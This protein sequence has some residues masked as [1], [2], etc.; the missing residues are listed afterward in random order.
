MLVIHIPHSST[1][2]PAEALEDYVIDPLIYQ[3]LVVDHRTDELFNG[4]EDPKVI[5]PYSRVFCDVERLTDDPLADKGQGIYYYKTLD[6]REL[7]KHNPVTHAHVMKL[8][9]EHHMRVVNEI[10]QGLSYFPKVCLVDAHSYSG[11]QANHALGVDTSH[12]A[13]FCIGTDELYTPKKLTAT[14]V[15][16]LRSRNYSVA[17]NTPFEGTLVP[18][19]FRGNK[20]FHSIMLEVNKNL[21]YGVGEERFE[22]LRADISILLRIIDDMSESIEP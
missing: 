14:V 12:Y 16:F 6:G 20:N 10:N 9:Y 3:G 11:Y 5:F 21:Y 18:D 1:A 13:D 7:R 2:L 19:E 4:T 22:A 8:Y 15:D 17:V